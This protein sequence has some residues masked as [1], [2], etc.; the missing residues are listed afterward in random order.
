MKKSIISLTIIASTIIFSGCTA[1]NQAVNTNAKA[2]I[3][4]EYSN[5]QKGQKLYSKLIF[6][7]C[8]IT[9][10]TMAKKYTQDEWEKFQLEGNTMEIIS[11]ICPI[12]EDWNPKEV[13]VIYDY[14]YYHAS[15]SGHVAECSD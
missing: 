14:M 3:D 2:S 10:N 1:S 7:S 13:R 11:D 12:V 6:R 5:P 9:C 8:G 4:T 15:D